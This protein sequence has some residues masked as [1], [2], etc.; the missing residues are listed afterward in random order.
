L[1][2]EGE[3]DGMTTVWKEGM[4]AWKPL[5]DVPEL[6]Q[7]IREANAELEG[8][9]SVSEPAFTD[10]QQMAVES[11]DESARIQQHFSK[12]GA[13]EGEDGVKDKEKF[14]TSDDGTPYVWDDATDG[15]KKA[16]AEEAKR[17]KQEML[18]A[19]QDGTD[20]NLKRKREPDKGTNVASADDA[21][22]DGPGKNEEGGKEDGQSATEE[23]KKKKKK[24]KSKWR[25][26]K[27]SKNTWVYFQGV[28]DDST[29]EEVVN[30]FKK[31]GI[32][33]LDMDGTP[34]IKFYR[35]EDGRLKGDGRICYLKP[36]SVV[37]A[38]DLLNEDQIRP[39]VIVK[40]QAAHFEQKG[41]AF[42]KKVVNN[43][44]KKRQKVKS[45]E[46]EQS[47]SWEEGP[48]TGSKNALRI[49]AIKHLFNAQQASTPG[50]FEQLEE[51][52]SQEC[53]KLG[54]IEKL[55]IFSKSLEG[56]VA[57]KFKDPFAATQCVEL[58]HKRFFDERQL[59]CFFW[60][61]VE[62]FA[63]KPQEDGE[64]DPSKREDAFGDWLDNQEV[65][66]DLQPEVEAE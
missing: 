51:D 12:E 60:D 46:M 29:E 63:A 40:V 43:Q 28:A 38:I 31:C 65:P 20:G 8:D 16:T 23:K 35:E 30:F 1:V 39:G 61:G 49:I 59:E 47:L 17:I 48:G 54:E 15:W 64:E 53:L 21:G 62:N 37:L 44:E 55:T 2:I 57:V 27:N 13:S 24:K 19:E 66:E 4:D 58:M 34:K 36:E 42:V 14:F 7:A 50:F 32:V 33:A 11:D 26:T 10:E 18:E 5:T 56:V 41:D 3:V 22:K 6:K 52:I 9:D 25:N 45:F